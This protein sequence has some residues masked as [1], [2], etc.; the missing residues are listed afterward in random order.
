MTDI[1]I[2]SMTKIDVP[3]VFALGTAAAELK[4]SASDTF[5]NQTVL[6]NWVESGDCLLVAEAEGRVVGFQLTQLHAP[7]KVGYLSDIAIDPEWRRH[8]IGSR[9]IEAAIRELQNRGANYI[10]GLTKLEN[11]KIHLLL[12]KLG[13]TKGNAFYWFEKHLK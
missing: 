9:L 5:W 1:H 13:F 3:A 12:E 6:E 10:Y 7:T 8:G 4:A 11:E 2:R